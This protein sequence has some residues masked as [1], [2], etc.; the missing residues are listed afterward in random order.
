MFELFDEGLIGDDVK[1]VQYRKDPN[2]GDLQSG[3]LVEDADDKADDFVTEDV[4][5]R[6]K[7]LIGFVLSEQKLKAHHFRQRKGLFNELD[8]SV[9]RLLQFWLLLWLLLMDCC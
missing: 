2:A 3:V 8:K 5:E 6:V 1:H 9:G 4:R 7:S